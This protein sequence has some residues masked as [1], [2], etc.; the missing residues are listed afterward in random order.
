MCLCAC[1]CECVCN[2]DF[3]YNSFTVSLQREVM[4]PVVF[5]QDNTVCVCLRSNFNNSELKCKQH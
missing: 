3:F 5:W 1:V 2:R 4:I